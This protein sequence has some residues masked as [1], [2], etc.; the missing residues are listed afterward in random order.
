VVLNR[1]H[2]AWV[3]CHGKN[4]VVSGSAFRCGKKKRNKEPRRCSKYRS[5]LLK[6]A[7]VRP[8]SLLSKK[9]LPL[10]GFLLSASI[11]SKFRLGVLV[12]V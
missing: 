9:D 2:D 7:P 3:Y 4:K 11:L 12:V 6:K 1:L 5:G 8:A 10:P